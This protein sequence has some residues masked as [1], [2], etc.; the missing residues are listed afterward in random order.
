MTA[1]K[2]KKMGSFYHHSVMVVRFDDGGE[3]IRVS[4]EHMPAEGGTKAL[5]EL[6]AYL[7]ELID[8]N[9]RIAE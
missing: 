5:G 7:S 6:K 4:S 8:E 2:R 3:Q 9:N 1:I